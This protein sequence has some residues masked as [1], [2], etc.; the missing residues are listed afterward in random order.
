MPSEPI[1]QAIKGLL[2][3]AAIATAKLDW[4]TVA[5]L[6]DAALKLDPENTDALELK[7]VASNKGVSIKRLLLDAAASTAK[8]DWNNVSSL[9]NTVLKLEPNNVDALKFKS[10]ASDH[11]GNTDSI[12]E[13]ESIG[14][15]VQKALDANEQTKAEALVRNYLAE[16]PD[17]Q[18]GLKAQN[19]VLEARQ[20][21]RVQQSALTR[22]ASGRFC[23]NCGSPM[24]RDVTSCLRCGENNFENLPTTTRT[25]SSGKFAIYIVVL[26]ILAISLYSCLFSDGREQL[27][28]A[29]VHQ[30]IAR[31]TNCSEL[32]VTFDQ[33]MERAVARPAG[34]ARGQVTASYAHTANLRMEEIGCFD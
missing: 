4:S 18:E 31:L 6:A 2:A 22:H 15:K 13:P 3:E 28:D 23:K 7:S 10:L 33:N 26:G 5:S 29:G 21:Q 9:A 25:I 30:D 32:Q 20:K 19:V 14:A 1:D 24:G 17:D 16:N 12:I 27:G 34:D 8:M 11:V